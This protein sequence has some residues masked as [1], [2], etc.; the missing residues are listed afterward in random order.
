[1][2]VGCFFKAPVVLTEKVTEKKACVNIECRS[3][4]VERSVK[5]CHDCGQPLGVVENREAIEAQLN[6]HD[7]DGEWEDY[8]HQVD[9][10]DGAEHYWIGRGVT[11][12]EYDDNK[13]VIMNSEKIEEA[14]TLFRNKHLA[15]SNAIEAKY[16]VKLTALYGVV[17]YYD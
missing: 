2:Y 9:I 5:F 10:D 1:V 4:G 12:S 14:L 8:M 11:M 7:F 16:G 3:H 17:P 6:I 15:F 13:T